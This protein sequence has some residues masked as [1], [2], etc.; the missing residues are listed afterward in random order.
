MSEPNELLEENGVFT[1]PPETC[2]QKFDDQ[3]Y[4]FVLKGNSVYNFRADGIFLLS[5]MSAQTIQSYAGETV[6][7]I[8]F[9]W[10]ECLVRFN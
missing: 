8:L 6:S 4:V 5:H 2:A 3:I 10:P 7:F 1:V 9:S